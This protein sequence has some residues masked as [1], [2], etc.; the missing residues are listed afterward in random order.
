MRGLQRLADLSDEA[1]LSPR[2]IAVGPIA[3]WKLKELRMTWPHSLTLASRG[4]WQL[5]K[6][7]EL[8]GE[9]GS[10][11]QRLDLTF[12]E[13]LAENISRLRMFLRSARPSSKTA[14]LSRLD[15]TECRPTESIDEH[16]G[17]PGRSAKKALTAFLVCAYLMLPTAPPPRLTT[18]MR[19]SDARPEALTA[20]SP[21]ASTMTR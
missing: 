5:S 21:R 18:C 9:D 8:L 17:E 12:P 4:V 3:A 11:S 14:E 10:R 16:P 1:H 7:H 20:R 15:G 6:G 13:L 2:L 19:S